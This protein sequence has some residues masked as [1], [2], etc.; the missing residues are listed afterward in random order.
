MPGL[1]VAS[2]SQL[3]EPGDSP[4]DNAERERLT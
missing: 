3:N 4:D 1:T 2:P